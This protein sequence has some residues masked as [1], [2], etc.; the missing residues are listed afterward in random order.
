MA[1]EIID[2]IGL[3]VSRIQKAVKAEKPKFNIV[4]SFDNAELYKVYKKISVKDIEILISETDRT[5]NIKER[6]EKSIPIQDYI[7]ENKEAFL[8]LTEKTSI[9]KIKE[10]EDLQDSFKDKIP[11][12]VKYDKNYL[13]QIYYSSEENKYFMLFPAKE[14]ETEVLMYML[15][16]KL[17]KEDTIIYVPICKES[18]DEKIIESKKLN[19]IENYI[20][21]FTTIWPQI[22]EIHDGED[23]K[24]YIIGK[25][26]VKEGFKTEYRIILNNKQEADNEF[27]LLKALFILTTET[28]YDYKFAPELDSNGSLVFEYKDKIVDFEN[29]QKFIT[30]ETALQQDLKY[31]YKKQIDKNTK[32]L[33]KLKEIIAKQN[34]VY[35]KQ[36]KQILDFMD[37]KNSFF[38]KVRFFFKSNKKFSS[39][40]KKLIKNIEQE[41]EK[42]EAIKDDEIKMKESI[43]KD[44]PNIF[45]IADLVKTSIEVKAEADENKKIKDDIK[46]LQLKRE[47]M[48]KKIENADKYL[49]EI[50]KHKKNL[51]DFWKFTNKDNLSMLSEGEV[52][53]KEEKKIPTFN[54]EEDMAYLAINSDKLQRKKLSNEECDAIFVASNLLEAI[55]SVVTRSNTYILDET[56]DELM[57]KYKKNKSGENL[58]G[59]MTDDYTKVKKLNNNEHREN[60]KDLFRIL[61]FNETTTLEDFKDRMKELG[62][63]V[64]EAYQKITSIYDMELY[65]SK[66]NKG[67]VIGE[68]NPY[69]FLEDESINKIY[70]MDANKDTHVIYFSNIVFYDNQNKT[71]PLGMDESTGIILKV[72]ENKKIS[73]STVNVLVRKD[74]FTVVVRKIKIVKEGKVPLKS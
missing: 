61:R 50:E 11:F 23:E 54:Y 16:K 72:G 64:T 4:K 37:C 62:R 35:T 33:E 38:K 55:N 59:G 56:Y 17:A 3:N 70:K 63:L 27:T 58:F 65:Y 73:D 48:K 68:V 46:A 8:E 51:V 2:Y 6:Y 34:E 29:I 20:W 71:L 67:F 32:K 31:T 49:D 24:I 45:T 15:K 60:H 53:P 43:L 30:D 18:Y 57:E 25:T 69:I 66:R 47:N 14:G 12:F 42:A 41:V 10:L 5:T 26:K 74:L 52:K 44:I 1:N 7:K 39:Y 9:E 22:Y 36:E 21:I 19:D 40:S 13:W 28:K